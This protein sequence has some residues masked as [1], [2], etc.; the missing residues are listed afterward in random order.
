MKE[1]A[2]AMRELAQQNRNS[3]FMFTFNG[4]PSKATLDEVIEFDDNPI[5]DSE[6]FS[7][8]AERLEYYGWIYIFRN[9]EYHNARP[10]EM[11]RPIY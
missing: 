2:Q 7:Y 4:Y 11:L 9:G 6:V 10:A 5:T 1:V 8:G 3:V